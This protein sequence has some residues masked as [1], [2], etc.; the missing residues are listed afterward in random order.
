MTD[1]YPHMIHKVAGDGSRQSGIVSRLLSGPS[2]ELPLKT[3]SGL[4]YDTILFYLEPKREA[5]KG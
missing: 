4:Y 3:Q 5:L 2:V 1:V